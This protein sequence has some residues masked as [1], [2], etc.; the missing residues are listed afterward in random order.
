MGNLWF[1]NQVKGNIEN[2]MDMTIRENF[3]TALKSSHQVT[4]ALP[5]ALRRLWRAA[6]IRYRREIVCVRIAFR[7]VDDWE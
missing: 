4:I 2:R 1:N 6:L 3:V 7:N 5:E